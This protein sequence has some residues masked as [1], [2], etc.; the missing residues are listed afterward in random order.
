MTLGQYRRA[1]GVFTRE[2]DLEYALNDLQDAGFPMNKVSAIA[3]DPKKSR[4]GQNLIKSPGH[5]VDTEAKIGSVT[6]TACGLL[7]GLF[8]SAAAITLLGIGPVLAAGT[9]GTT[10]AT[11]LAGGGIGAV[12]GGLLGALAGLGIPGDKAKV[13]SDRLAR[14][15]YLLAIEG[16][17]DE[18]M[19]AEMI[20]LN[21]R[22]I[23]EWG[24]YDIPS[25]D[26]LTGKIN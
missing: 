21:N 14:G 26:S 5:K 13:Y 6:G 11:T 17:I 8:A 16:K 23:E 10:L 7:T 18:I 25:E 22:G 19:R 15:D 1:I 3:K 4:E 2:Q 20:L 12:S 24:I 9:V